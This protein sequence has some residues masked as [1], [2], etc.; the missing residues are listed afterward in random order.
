MFDIREALF[1]VY[2]MFFLSFVRSWPFI[3][4]I[5]NKISMATSV[6]AAR[7]AKLPIDIHVVG[8]PEGS[9]HEIEAAF[10]GSPF[11]VVYESITQT[12][13]P[14]V[15][16]AGQSF[17]EMNGGVDGIVNSFLS[18]Y[19]SSG[20]YVQARVKR[21]IQ[22]ECGGELGVGQCLAVGTA[23]P[24]VRTLLYTAT[25]RVAEPVSDTLNAYLAFRAAL[26]QAAK[27]DVRG[28]ASPLFCTGDGEMPVGRAC[29]QMRAAYDS[30]VFGN[31]VQRATW[32][33]FHAH[34]RRLKAL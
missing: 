16:T 24:R 10:R 1:F 6:I 32:T 18:S 8:V 2:I 14:C 20:E 31:D 15:I 9:R 7:L 5:D 29:R 27:S 19:D 30:I 4:L 25:M 28:V 3:F 11:L 26:V 33:D 21:A 34:H 13:M 12:R 22:L 23:H 17:G